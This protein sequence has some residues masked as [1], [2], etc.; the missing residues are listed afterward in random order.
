MFLASTKVVKN[1][2]KNRMIFQIG[3]VH[4]NGVGIYA[5]LMWLPTNEDWYQVEMTYDLRWQLKN[6]ST[7]FHNAFEVWSQLHLVNLGSCCQFVLMERGVLH[8]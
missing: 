3:P 5:R 8:C 2:Q 6:A 4:L 1:C 7:F